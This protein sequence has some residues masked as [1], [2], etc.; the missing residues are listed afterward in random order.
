MKKTLLSLTVLLLLSCSNEDEK[1]ISSNEIVGVWHLTD[2]LENGKPVAGY[3]CNKEFDIT[4]FTDS[5]QSITKYSDKN[6]NDVCLQY[7]D[8]GNYSISEDIL[9]DVQMNGNIKIYEAK[10]KIKE[11]TAASLKLEQISGYE[12]D[13]KGNNPHSINY[14]EGEFV[15]LYIH[16]N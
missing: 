2:I 1:R 15:K 9:T 11:L 4:E 13:P 16:K 7:T 14:V 6:S 5:G 3:S 10:Y 12:T 8:N